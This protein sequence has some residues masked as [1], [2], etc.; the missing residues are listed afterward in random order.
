MSWVAILIGFR[1][2]IQSSNVAILA[3]LGIT[4]TMAMITRINRLVRW[5][6]AV[7]DSCKKL[8]QEG[9]FLR[10]YPI[11]IA[12]KRD[13]IPS[14]IGKTVLNYRWYK[15]RKRKR[16]TVMYSVYTSS[17]YI[18]YICLGGKMPKKDNRLIIYEKATNLIIYSKNLLNK[19]PK[20]ERFDLC[21]DIKNTLI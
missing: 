11:R 20:S 9:I 13:I 6:C 3:C 2:A 12:S 7:P 21:A 17:L 14:S 1:R 19:Y 5:L 8:I 10:K 18:R 4:T 15:Q 16:H